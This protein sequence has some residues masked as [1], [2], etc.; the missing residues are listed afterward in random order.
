MS[1]RT[2]ALCFVFA[3]AASGFAT[4]AEPR[5][6]EFN[7]DVRPILSDHCFQC[8]GPDEKQRKAELRLDI[9]SG[10]LAE[11]DGSRAVVPGKLSESELFQRITS[12]DENERMPPAKFARQLS[13]EQIGILKR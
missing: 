5:P 13:A 9:E 8:H 7:R 11:H 1:L 2:A 4:A 12:Q 3:I 10:A 6:V